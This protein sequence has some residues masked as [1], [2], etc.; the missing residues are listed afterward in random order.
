MRRSR[1]AV[2]LPPS[3]AIPA[4][5]AVAL[6]CFALNSLLCRMALRSGAIDPASFSAVRLGS[7]AIALVIL[8]RASS[9]RA[10]GG[11]WTSAA[12]L[13]AYA[14]PFSFAYLQLTAGTGALI[15]FGCVQASMIGWGL[16]R[17]EHPRP[18]EWIG[19]ALSLAGLVALVLPSLTAPP[20][21][22][23]ALMAVAG[24]AWSAYTLRGRGA[25]D[26]LAANAGNFLRT[27]PAV[28]A[29]AAAAA[30]LGRARGTPYGL[31]L[32]LT[33]G[34]ICSGIGYAVWYAA[35]RGLTRTHAAIV[36]LAVPVVAGLGGVVLLGE[37]VSLRLLASGAAILSG[38]ALAV[39]PRR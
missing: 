28:A 32:A 33:S 37:V 18:R 3:V 5:T 11:S 1:F 2:H 27:V 8:V 17:G 30:F 14:V 13:L 29:I 9:E 6:L 39:V 15:L 38:V 22:S 19:L 4:A 31:G 35:L 10:P 26:P 7:G 34:A 12:M 21:G 36:Q 16:W 24:V 20:P 25:P 23:A